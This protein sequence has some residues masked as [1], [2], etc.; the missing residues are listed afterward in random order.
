[1]LPRRE[2]L[3]RLGYRFEELASDWW[4]WRDPAGEMFGGSYRT[5]ER[6]VGYAW[7]RFCH[8]NEVLL[9]KKGGIYQRLGLIRDADDGRTRVRY[10]HLWPHQMEEWVRDVAEFD[11]GR[12]VRAS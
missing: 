9:H 1:M 6:A 4:I 5:E 10:L 8:F 12:F 11:D 2:I 7:R 3:E